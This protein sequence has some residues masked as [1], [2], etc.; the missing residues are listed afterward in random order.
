MKQYGECMRVCVFKIVGRALVLGYLVTGAFDSLVLEEV[1][2]ERADPMRHACR[3]RRDSAWSECVRSACAAVCVV[4][5][6]RNC[7]WVN[8]FN[9]FIMLFIHRF[10]MYFVFCIF[11]VPIFL[12][13]LRIAVKSEIAMCLYFCNTLSMDLKP[14]N[15]V[16]VSFLHFSSILGA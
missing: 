8:V 6:R 5:W 2:D 11:N 15:N 16:S 13:C 10:Q 3:A 1:K 14:E 4:W 12:M 7:C 9:V